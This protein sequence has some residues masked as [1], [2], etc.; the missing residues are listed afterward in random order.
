MNGGQSNWIKLSLG[1]VER[2]KQN[3]RCEGKGINRTFILPIKM[4]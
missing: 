3:P 4:Q 1:K 2:E